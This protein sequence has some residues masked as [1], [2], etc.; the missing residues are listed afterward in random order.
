MSPSSV[1]RWSCGFA[2]ATSIGACSGAGSSFELRGASNEE[3]RRTS[4]AVEDP[5]HND[6]ENDGPDNGGDLGDG[7]F[8]GEA[9]SADRNRWAEERLLMGRVDDLE[10][11]PVRDMPTGSATYDGMATLRYSLGPLNDSLLGDLQLSAD[12]ASATITGEAVNWESEI[13]GGPIPGHLSLQAEVKGNG[14]D[15]LANGTFINDGR[16]VDI[17]DAVMAGA[18]LGNAGEALAGRFEGVATMRNG[19]SGDVLGT[20]AAERQP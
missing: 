3:P 14:L 12:F 7:G 17:V 4:P 2:L 13:V 16:P 19:A 5:H 6:Q 10:L 15:G 1:V 8:G 20:F 18:F 9:P 11:T